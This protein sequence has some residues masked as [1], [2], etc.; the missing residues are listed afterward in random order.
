M[1]THIIICPTEGLTW[2]DVCELWDNGV[3]TAEDIKIIAPLYFE[4]AELSAVLEVV[5]KV[6]NDSH[7]RKTMST[8]LSTDLSTDPGDYHPAPIKTNIGAS[9]HSGFEGVQDGS[10]ADCDTASA[11]GKSYFERAWRGLH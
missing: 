10:E 9:K 5:E 6:E 7:T 11:R 3:Y 8:D 4:G 2:D 1:C